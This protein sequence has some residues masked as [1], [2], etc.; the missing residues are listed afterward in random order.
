MR[1]RARLSMKVEN[2]CQVEHSEHTDSEA[3]LR[4]WIVYKAVEVR[5]RGCTSRLRTTTV[6]FRTSHVTL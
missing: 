6:R 3:G 4:L 1:T 2:E 5:S